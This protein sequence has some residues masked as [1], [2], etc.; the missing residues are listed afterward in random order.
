MTAPLSRISLLLAIVLFVAA[1]FQK[2]IAEA[3][4][5][6]MTEPTQLEQ[7]F[8]GVQ[9]AMGS[10]SLVEIPT[11]PVSAT[12]FWIAVV[13]A[14]IALWAWIVENSFW[15][16]LAAMCIALAAAMLKMALLPVVLAAVRGGA[17]AKR[18][19]SSSSTSRS[20]SSKSTTQ[21]RR[22]SSSKSRDS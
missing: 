12:I 15:I 4:G 7:V 11:H 9:S 13:I 19:S 21:R 14:A 22:S 1:L 5:K 17:Q 10:Q 16:P 2:Q 3:V 18:R 8:K 20:T 6:P